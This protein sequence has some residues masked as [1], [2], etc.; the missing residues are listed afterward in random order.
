MGGY[1]GNYKVK[2]KLIESEL[3]SIGKLFDFMSDK[4]GSQRKKVYYLQAGLLSL[5]R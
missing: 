4:D 1:Y 3:S 2:A 5:Q